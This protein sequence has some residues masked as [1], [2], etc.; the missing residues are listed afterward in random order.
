MKITR[1][2][3]HL[4]TYSF[5]EEK[6]WW[7]GS[8][9]LDAKAVRFHAIILRVHTDEG[10]TGLGEASPWGDCL[11]AEAMIHR[12]E[13]RFLGRDPFDVE[14]LTVH[15]GD[16][17][18][19][20]VLGPID[21][22]LWDI[23]G[24]ATQTPV[25]RLLAQDGDLKP[26]GIR[27]YASGGLTYNWFDSTDKI[28]DE[29]LS[30]KA[31]GF[32][33]FK[34]RIGSAW[35]RSGVTMKRFGDHLARVRAT[36]G[37]EMDLM[38][39]ANGRFRSVAEAME[40]CRILE[41]V[42]AR[43]FEEPVSIHADGGPARYAEI[44]S[45]T[46]VPISG[47]EV[48]HSVNEHLALLRAGAYGIVQPDASFMGLTG[49]YR[50]ARM[51]HQAG[52]PCIPHSWTNAIA[53]AANAHLVA[54]IPNRVMLETQQIG[55]VMLTDLVDQPIPV[56]RGSID[57]PERPGLGIELDMDAVKRHPFA[58]NG[59]TIPWPR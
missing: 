16:D 36:M 41:G 12:L 19:N 58:E 7:G 39:D 51:Y 38:L 30:Y 3:T 37:D 59:I 56:D 54:A 11:A 48:V 9:D 53:H 57:V 23:I 28:F 44:R 35:G 42:G 20:S 8:W 49:A 5:T 21:C 10:I 2:E 26:Q 47:G 15:T 52:L 22:A 55:N 32:A 34:M 43:W 4:C 17:R 6:I 46:S 27:T 14:K 31:L 33:A 25:Y 13:P 40:V 45:Q 18:V 24:K 1:F 29:V 50:V